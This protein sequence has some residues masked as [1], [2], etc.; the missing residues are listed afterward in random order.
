MPGL[1]QARWDSVFVEVHLHGPHRVDIL[2]G[3]AAEGAPPAGLWTPTRLG[4][5]WRPGGAFEGSP[6]IW[7]EWDRPFVPPREP[8][9][10]VGVSTAPLGS[11]PLPAGRDAELARAVLG[12]HHPAAIPALERCLSALDGVGA[13]LHVGSLAA[14][15]RDAARLSFGIRASAVAPWLAR[16][17]WPGDAGAVGRALFRVQPPFAEVGVQVELVPE[18]GPYLGFECQEFVDGPLA[19]AHAEG[20][21][22]AVAGLARMDRDPTPA[23][24]DWPGRDP[25]EVRHA[26]LKLV[27][28]DPWTTKLYLGLTGAAATG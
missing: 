12:R 5:E 19:R 11:A 22:R 24:R 13:L 6:L 16:A 4:R 8:L 7:L 10:W 15:G 1:A 26:Y 2:A 9:S 18:L 28:G 3:R 14:R 23:L 17:G 27:A 20:H 21:V 25:G